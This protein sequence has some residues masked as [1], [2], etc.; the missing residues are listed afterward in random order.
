MMLFYD[1]HCPMCSGA[2]RFVLAR[3][4]QARF[5]PLNG[6]LARQILPHGLPDT[7]AVQTDDRRILI[8]SDAWVYILRKIPFPWK[9]AGVLLGVIPRPI[10]NAVYRVIAMIRRSFRIRS[11]TC[12][13]IPA[14]LRSRF[15]P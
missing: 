6:T 12:P 15:V 1:D 5:S 4:P 2:V 8:L 7:M 13:L 11:E 14:E 9:A 10:R 3:D